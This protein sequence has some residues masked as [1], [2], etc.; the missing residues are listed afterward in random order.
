MQPLYGL[1]AGGR[2][3][4]V[5]VEVAR[6]RSPLDAARRLQRHDDQRVAT[7]SGRR[8]ALILYHVAE[9]DLYL[10]VLPF[11]ALLVL[12][13]APRHLDRPPPA[14]S[15]PPRSRSPSGSS[16]E[17]AAFASRATSQRIEERN[18]FYL[19]PLALI[20]L[21]ALVERGASPAAAARPSSPPRSSPASCPFFIPFT[22]FITTSAVSDTFA[23]LPGGGRRTT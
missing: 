20:A 2:A 17:V 9:L 19:A 6:G 10:G 4:A 3:R 12:W 7:P 22:R 21:L 13:L 1:R 14:R 5:V 23:L 16:L 15:P 18:M 8:F 11:A